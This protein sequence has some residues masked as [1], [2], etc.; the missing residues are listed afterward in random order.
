MHKAWSDSMKIQQIDKIADITES[1]SACAGHGML[2]PGLLRPIH[3][4][5]FTLKW[6]SDYFGEIPFFAKF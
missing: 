3:T 5:Y 6:H 1:T 2:L 4:I